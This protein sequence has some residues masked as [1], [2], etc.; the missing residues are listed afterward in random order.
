MHEN[1]V[2]IDVPMVLR[3]VE[4]QFPR[5]ADLAIEPVASAGTDNALFRLGDK[6][7]VRLPR[8]DWAVDMVAKE[9]RWL[10]VLGPHLTLAIPRIVGR[11]LP[12]EGYPWPWSIQTWLPGQNA[13]VSR[14]GNPIQFARDLARFIISLQ[15]VDPIGGPLPG[16]HNAGRGVSLAARDKATRKALRE[17]KGE[18][19]AR[20]AAAAWREALDVPAWERPPV[21]LHGDLQAGNLLVQNGRLTAV[22]DFGCA[23]VG[24]PACD[25]A[26]A[27]NLFTSDMRLPFQ[28][29]LA[30]D[31][32]TW[33]RGRGWA[34]SIALIQLPY[35]KET[36]PFLAA[37]ARYAIDQVLEEWSKGDCN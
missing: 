13:V 15:D 1:E 33:A 5:W 2:D 17:L 19:D 21:W 36:N 29:T 20:A 12:G 16:S 28:E 37:A 4:S 3:L 18:I 23:G 24:D 6:L 31:E 9:Q 22:I 8:I 26:V 27:W 25:L 30:V 11:G 10:P 14:L 32:A 34:L 35:Y 7:V